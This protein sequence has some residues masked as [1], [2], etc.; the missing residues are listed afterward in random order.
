MLKEEKSKIIFLH[1]PKAGGVTLS[2]ILRNN[3]KRIFQIRGNCVR[4]D[5][6]E[7]KQ[8]SIEEIE[9]YDCIMG[10]MGFGLHKLFKSNVTYFTI[11]RDPVDRLISHYF[12]VL[13]YPDHYLY[14][15]VK[16]GN[17][18]FENYINSDLTSELYNGQTR[19]LAGDNGFPITFKDKMKLDNT[20]L[21]KAKNNLNKHF[22]FVGILKNYNL[23]LI[24]LK[25]IFN[26][27][28]IFYYKK[29]VSAKRP[30]KNDISDNVKSIIK[31]NNQLDIELIEYAKDLFQEKL[32]SLE[33]NISEELIRFNRI[34]KLY[35]YAFEPFY[36][37]KKHL[38]FLRRC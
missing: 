29:N 16:D 21:E 7:L 2:Q 35:G 12:Y 1:I 18:T 3:Y 19:L 17:L 25:Y 28:N 27:K 31:I 13:R 15:K 8:M 26:W 23:N 34:N 9:S 11:L 14:K 5:I 22:S 37:I 32:S 33:V 10:H 20:D 4:K 6:D 38:S 30:S 36:K 24:I